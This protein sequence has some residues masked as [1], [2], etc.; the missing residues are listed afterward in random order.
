VT[1]IIKLRL[2]TEQFPRSNTRKRLALKPKL[3]PESILW[4][5]FFE[6]INALKMQLNPKKTASIKKRN[7]ESLLST[8]IQVII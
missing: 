8:E 7:S 1:R 2:I 3:D 5:S 6:E 4:P